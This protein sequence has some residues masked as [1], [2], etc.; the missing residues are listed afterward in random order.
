MDPGKAGDAIVEVAV[1]LAFI[2]IG[3]AFLEAILYVLL[4]RVLRTRLAV[5]LMLV[6]PAIVGLLLL[7]AAP[8]AW[9]FYLS[10]TNM[11]LK[12][13]KPADVDLIGLDNFVRVFTKPVLKQV[14]FY[15]LFGQTLLWTSV[16]VTLHV[17]G[18]LA[19]ALTL[20]RR[21]RFKGVYRA[22]IILPWAVPQIVALFIWRTEYNFEYGVVNQLLELVGVAPIK[23]LTDPLWNFAAMIVAN[24]WLGI[25]FMMVIILGGLQSI[26]D[27]YYEAAQMD[28]ASSRQ[29]FRY[30]T[31]PLLQPVL[32]PAIILG[33]IWTFNNINVSFFINQNE[34]ETSDI[35]VTAL[36]RAAFQYN[37][38]GFA[39]A[40]AFVIFAIL[41]IFTVFY[42]WRTQALKGA[43]E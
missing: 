34:M 15:Q 39:A 12:H 35:L 27:E 41:L 26:S 3:V 6:A 14:G 23:W 33:V 19:L 4:V 5:P 8:I 16:N 11:S 30:I 17:L 2:A 21:L 43:Y 28:G 10:L 24:V 36:F 25:P 1:A 31:W 40:F 38:Y 22:I 9:E 18:G 7:N 37:Q 20:H 13:F 29:S 32:T 42:V